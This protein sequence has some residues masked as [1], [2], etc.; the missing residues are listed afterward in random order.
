MIEGRRTGEM[1]EGNKGFKE[2]LSGNW[3]EGTKTGRSGGA[4]G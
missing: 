4:E 3:N 2:L 1:S